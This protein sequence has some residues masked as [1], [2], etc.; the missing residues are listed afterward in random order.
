[1]GGSYVS[2]Q[3][4]NTGTFGAPI[5]LLATRQHA[6]AHGQRL[7]VHDSLQQGKNVLP[8]RNGLVGGR[9]G[10]EL[11]ELAHG[12]DNVVHVRHHCGKKDGK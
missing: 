3:P 5:Q 11:R 4:K 2:T 12:G 6:H 1:V 9:G 8:R 10:N 7:G